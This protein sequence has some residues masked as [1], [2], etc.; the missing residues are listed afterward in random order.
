MPQSNRMRLTV[1]FSFTALCM[2]LATP[3]PAQENK[4]LA[5]W[6]EPLSQLFDS[7]TSSPDDSGR[8]LLGDRFAETFKR[9]LAKEGSYI[10]PF[11]RL[12]A[13]SK[14][15]S[16]DSRLR[17]YT[18]NIPLHSGRNSFYGFIQI[19]SSLSG[20]PAVI[21]LKEPSGNPF[22][23]DTATYTSNRW[24]G[25]IYYQIITGSTVHGDPFYTVLGWR[26]G[27]MLLTARIID[28]LSVT[29][30]GEIRFGKPVFCGYGEE[31]PNRILFQHSPNATMTLRYEKQSVVTDKQWNAR[32]KEFIYEREQVMMI[33]CDRLIPA[34]P[35]LEGQF[36]YYLPAGDIMDGFVFENGCWTFLKDVDVRNPGK[37]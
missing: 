24:Y 33:V 37:N 23:S 26:G 30:A 19:Q 18:W 34:N 12:T 6:E 13:I 7:I 3:L 22:L 4:T 27:N 10:Y 25:A 11:P 29:P 21:E 28:I 35:D 16:E 15:T 1:V 17:I 9:L 32:K 2:A 8:M 36:E 5:Q 14:P 20:E 31:K